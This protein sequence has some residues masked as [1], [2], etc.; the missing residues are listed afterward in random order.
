MSELSNSG[1]TTDEVTDNLLTRF[2][3]IQAN[4]SA[5][6]DDMFMNVMGVKAAFVSPT[7][8]TVATLLSSYPA[9]AGNRGKYAQVNDLWGSVITVMVCEGDVSGY[10]WRPQRTDYAANMTIAQGTVNLVPLLTQ[11]NVRMV[12]SIT[13]NITLS[14]S[15][16]NVWPGASFDVTVKTA[17]PA[18]V[19][20]N[21]SGLIG[22][23][24]V[25]LLQGST[26]RITYYQG[27]GWDAS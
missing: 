25:P 1:L 11:P 6:A 9:S 15:V 3:T 14:P 10:Y 13:G 12:G 22:G 27:A 17:I 5:S 20:I 4:P 23:G 19:S 24:T 16:T 26:R 8:I 18:L 21:I 7:P 2:R